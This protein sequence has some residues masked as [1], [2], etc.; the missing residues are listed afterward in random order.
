MKKVKIILSIFPIL[1]LIENIFGYNG[2]MI[3]V[4]GKA[5]RHWLY[6]FTFLSLAMQFFLCIREEKYKLFSLKEK[7]YIKELSK[8]DWCTVALC[9]SFGIW[10]VLVPMIN[11]GSLSY[12]KRDAFDALCILV[13]YFP[14]SFLIRKKWYDWKK[15]EGIIYIS[16]IIQS[17]LHMVFYFGETLISG[18]MEGAFV[19]WLKVFKDALLPPIILGHGNTARAIF[20]T[21]MF[22]Y[23]GILICLKKILIEKQK[24]KLHYLSLVILTLASIC[25]MTKSIWF[26]FVG[27]TGLVMLVR[28]FWERKQFYRKHVIQVVLLVVAV[29][30]VSDCTVFGGRVMDK[31]GNAFISSLFGDSDKD[32]DENEKLEEEASKLSNDLKIKQVEYLLEKWQKSPIIGHGYGAYCED[33]IR[34]EEAV[35][36]YEMLAPALLMKLGIAGLLVWAVYFVAMLLHCYK[37][38]RLGYFTLWT[39]VL[40]SYGLAIQ[41]NPFMFSFAGILTI[42]YL[43][44]ATENG[45]ARET[46]EV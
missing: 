20:S 11:N 46:Y 43:A 16:V 10:M 19:L 33:F 13:L 9:V 1:F 40:M 23:V 24:N 38:S 25:T 31:V 41:T 29:V 6:L 2:T 22:L 8:F 21:S 37:R 44:L 7:S 45:V 39:L 3:M 15:I 42:L 28:L 27:A 14:L 18:F 5:I 4:G 12:A 32:K 17:I 36:S 35:F 34:S 30:L 26:G